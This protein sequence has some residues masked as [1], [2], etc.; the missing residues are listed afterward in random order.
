MK[1]QILSI[2]LGLVTMAIG[3]TTY[4]ADKNPV[5]ATKFT[6]NEKAVNNSISSF[7][8]L[9]TDGLTVHSEI[10]GNKVTSAYDK[11]GDWLYTIERHTAVSL[12]K[13][14][15]DIV[16]DSY[17]NY[18]IT[19]MEKVDRPGHNTVYVVHIEDRNSIKTLRVRNGEVELMQDFQRG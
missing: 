8:F 3:T 17:S 6:V 9:T 16:K 13:D 14:I 5:N 11:N 19:G 15:M 1:K 2:A 4:A 10:D 18:S 7:I 12:L